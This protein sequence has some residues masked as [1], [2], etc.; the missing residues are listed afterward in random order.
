MSKSATKWNG[1]KEMLDLCHCSTEETVY[2]GD[3]H[4]DLEPIKC[5]AWGLRFPM[6]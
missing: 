4:D 1:I 2:F 3:D 6:E 5:V